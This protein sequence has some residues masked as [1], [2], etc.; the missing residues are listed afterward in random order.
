M[1]AALV[2]AAVVVILALFHIL[3]INKALVKAQEDLYVA[4]VE[5]A[6]MT[7]EI[8]RCQRDLAARD[9]RIGEL[10]AELRETRRGIEFRLGSWKQM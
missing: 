10:A 9:T 7:H 6:A 4:E 5:A 8:D 1:L 3:S 2:L